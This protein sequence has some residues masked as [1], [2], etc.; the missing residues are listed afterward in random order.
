[1][2]LNILSGIRIFP[3]CVVL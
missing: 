2:A 3:D 1:M